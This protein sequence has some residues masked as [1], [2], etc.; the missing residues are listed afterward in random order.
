[1]AVHH[2]SAGEIVD[3]RPIGDGLSRARTTAIV[4]TEAFEAMR[5][6]IHAGTEIPA[7]QVAGEITLHCLEGAVTLGL[8][9]S[10]VELKAGQ[11]VYLDGGAKHSVKAVEDSSL[12]LTILFDASQRA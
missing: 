12:L 5:L 10:S 2:A 1:M 3:L 8:D 11:W 9:G 6:V 4:K 7:H